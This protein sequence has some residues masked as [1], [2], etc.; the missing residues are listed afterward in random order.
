MEG[1]ADKRAE[2]LLAAIEASKKQ[3]LPRLIYALGIRGV[4]ETVAALLA[5]RFGSLDAKKARK[6]L[7]CVPFNGEARLS[8]GH[9]HS[10]ALLTRTPSI[11]GG[12]GGVNSRAPYDQATAA[13]IGPWAGGKGNKCAPAP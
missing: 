7:G 11:A 2:N 3:S 1:F 8:C 12:P 9:P 10:G 5:E 4:G 13:S 6:R